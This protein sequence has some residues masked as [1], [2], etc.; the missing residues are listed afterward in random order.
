MILVPARGSWVFQ[1]VGSGS[2]QLN[3]PHQQLKHTSGWLHL[4]PSLAAGGGGGGTPC[5]PNR[6][7]KAWCLVMFPMWQRQRKGAQ[8]ALEKN[9]QN[10]S[11]YLLPPRVLLG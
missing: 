3:Q 9:R 5:A 7:R 1:S 4:T 8:Q 10:F 6:Q 2:L 11:T